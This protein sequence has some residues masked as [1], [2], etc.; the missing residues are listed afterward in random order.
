MAMMGTY[1]HYFDLSRWVTLGQAVT[2]DLIFA[3]VP[4]VFQV[5]PAEITSHMSLLPLY[6]I[7]KRMTTKEEASLAL[8]KRSELRQMEENSTQQMPYILASEFASDRDFGVLFQSVKGK[9]IRLVIINGRE[10]EIDSCKRLKSFEEFASTTP[11]ACV[12]LPYLPYSQVLS[13][14]AGALLVAVPTPSWGKPGS[15][16]TTVGDGLRMGRIV[17]VS[18]CGR[19]GRHQWT[20]IIRHGVNGFVVCDEDPLAWPSL[21]SKLLSMSHGGRRMLED[22]ILAFD[23]ARFSKA[24]LVRALFS[25]LTVLLMRAKHRLCNKSFF[26]EAQKENANIS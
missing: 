22:R 9:P 23:G 10:D 17:A 16:M 15:G 20:G 24:A 18:G 19:A 2:S 3:D 13:L 5:C 26:P 1:R 6:Y 14:M 4:H 21:I 25:E 7:D 11:A 12:L 8:R